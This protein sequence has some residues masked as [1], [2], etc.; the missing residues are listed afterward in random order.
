MKK[1]GWL[2]F[3]AGTGIVTAISCGDS[4]PILATIGLGVFGVCFFL[5]TFVGK[6]TKTQ[7]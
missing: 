1:F 2:N 3:F 7:T 6:R 4:K 5:D